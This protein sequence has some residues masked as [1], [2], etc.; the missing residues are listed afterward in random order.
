[1]KH[2]MISIKPEWVE[3]ILNGEKTLEIRKSCPIEDMPCKVYIYETKAK[4]FKPYH[5]SYIDKTIY[6]EY[7]G[8]GKVV[9]EF[10]LMHLTQFDVDGLVRAGFMN[11]LL[12]QSCLTE[13]QLEDYL[14]D[15]TGYAWHIEDLHI[16]DTPK[17]LGEFST[18]TKC[19]TYIAK[20]KLCDCCCLCSNFCKTKPKKLTRPPQSWCYIKG[21]DNESVCD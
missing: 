6:E 12:K 14:G 11:D 7:E 17:E 9:A 2:I 20:S 5:N 1:M 19:N 16:Y 15:K 13:E 18:L 21:K 10:T 8:R 4:W 3:K